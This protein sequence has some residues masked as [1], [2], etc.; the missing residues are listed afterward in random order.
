MNHILIALG[1]GIVA[2]IIDITPMIIMK[3]DK[4]AN[5]SAFLHYL[6]L[7]LIIPFVHWEI[8]QWLTGVFVSLLSAIPIMIL[9]AQKDKKALI[10]MFVFAIILGAGIGFAGSS[11][12]G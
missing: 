12:M 6:A 4:R 8:P 10:P 5:L 1:I 7:G 9:V 3:L 11:F 2:G